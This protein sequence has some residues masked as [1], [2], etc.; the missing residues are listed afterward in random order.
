ML[1][2]T[3]PGRI[4]DLIWALPTV[5]AFAIEHGPVRLWVSPWCKPLSNLLRKQPYIQGIEIDYSWPVMDTAPIT[6]RV[7]PCAETFYSQ[8]PAAMHEP[9]VHLGYDK[10]PSMPLPFYTA[11]HLGKR[12]DVI[13]APW[14]DASPFDGQTIAV[15][16]HWTDRW[17]ELKYGLTLWL[18]EQLG[19]RLPVIC[20]PDSARWPSA[21]ATPLTFE[22]LARMMVKTHLVLTDNSA[23][24][25]LAAAMGRRSAIVEPEQDRHHFIFWPGSVQPGGKWQQAKNEFGKLVFPVIG[26]DG[27]PTFDARHTKDTISQLLGD[28]P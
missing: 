24:M 11:E 28:T 16:C 1:T 9:V 26:G 4:G 6:P 10:W 15:L 18:G 25:V 2:V 20:S 22:N 13:F 19:Y 23:A 17:F 5:R 21:H 12:S 27:K 14:I 3:H 8:E 7:P